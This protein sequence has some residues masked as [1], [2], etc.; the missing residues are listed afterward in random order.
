MKSPSDRGRISS[1]YGERTLEIISRRQLLD[2]RDESSI[3]SLT[4][5]AREL[6]NILLL[7]GSRD[8]NTSVAKICDVAGQAESSRVNPN[9]PSKPNPLHTAAQE[10]VNRRHGDYPRFRS[11]DAN[12]AAIAASGGLPLNW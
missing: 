9:K 1:S 7:A 11:N 5:D 3:R 12:A 6:I 10:Q 4:N 2:G 8:F